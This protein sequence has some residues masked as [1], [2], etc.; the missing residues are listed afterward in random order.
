MQQQGLIDKK[1]ENEIA[2]RYR[3]ALARKRKGGKPKGNK[4]EKP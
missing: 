1:D 3:Y 4:G 2:L